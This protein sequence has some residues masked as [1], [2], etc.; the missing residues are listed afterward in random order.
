M[1]Q[2]EISD[3]AF[4]AY[5]LERGAQYNAMNREGRFD[6]LS[7]D[8]KASLKLCECP[9]CSYYNYLFMQ[10]QRMVLDETNTYDDLR[11]FVV[12]LVNPQLRELGR[13]G[14]TMNASDF[15]CTQ[16]ANNTESEGKS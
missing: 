1:E 5:C 9:F 11:D 13:I 15:Q 2:V 12:K 14:A 10:Q 4:Y 8:Q 16:C 7:D 6:L 3:A